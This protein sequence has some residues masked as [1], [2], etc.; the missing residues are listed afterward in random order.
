[1]SQDFVNVKTLKRHY[2]L[3][4]AL[5]SVSRCWKYELAAFPQTSFLQTNSLSERI[6]RA[7]EQ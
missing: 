2:A 3:N 1:M 4:I 5:F 7:N 6:N